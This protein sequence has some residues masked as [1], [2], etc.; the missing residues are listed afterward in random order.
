MADGVTTCVALSYYYLSGNTCS[1]FTRI[2]RDGGSTWDN[3]TQIGPSFSITGAPLTARGYFL[4]DYHGMDAGASSKFV[5]GVYSSVGSAPNNSGPTIVSF[6]K[7]QF[8]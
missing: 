5:C 7:I 6:Y 3:E 1:Y 8:S 4:G 2:S